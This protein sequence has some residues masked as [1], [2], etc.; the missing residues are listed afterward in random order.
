MTPTHKK[1]RHGTGSM[2]PTTLNRIRTRPAANTPA[3]EM[4]CVT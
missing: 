1:P 3:T 2:A 4:G